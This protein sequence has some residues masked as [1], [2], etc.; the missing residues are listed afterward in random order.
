[1]P[2]PYF[3]SRPAGL[4]VRFRVPED[5]RLRI[6]L[7]FVVRSMHGLRGDAARL[8]A[9]R[10]AVALSAVFHRLR[11]GDDVTGFDPKKLID[12]AQRAAADGTLREWTATGVRIGAVDFGAVTTQGPQDTLDFIEAMKAAAAIAP[13]MPMPVSAPVA[14]VPEPIAP[15][16]PLLSEAIA[17]YLKDLESAKRDPKT[18]LESRH[19]LRILLGVVG[20]VAVGTLSQ[21][22]VRAFFDA[23]RHWPSN[24]TKRPEY[25][26]LSVPEVLVLSKA[27]K[28]P[29]P[30][31][32][33]L[34]K[35]RQRLSA[36]VQPLLAA[37]VISH[38][39]M[40]G[41]VRMSA[42][43]ASAEVET[44]R[45]FTTAELQAVFAPLAYLPWAKKYPHRYWA[46]ILG[47]YSGAR[48][49]EVA[50]L[51]VDDIETV[52]GVPGFHVNRRF[53]GQKIKNAQS[54]RFVP[55]AQPVLDVG[56][57]RFV[58]EA[59]KAGQA[60]LFPDLPNGT[61]LG[62]GRQL[63]RQFSAYIKK[64]GVVEEG[65]GFHAFRH[66]FATLLSEAGVET[67]DIARLTGHLD[68]K[69]QGSVLEKFYIDRKTLPLRVATLARFTPAVGMPT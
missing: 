3:L 5:L 13:S 27:R 64:C 6:G 67:T 41:I 24:A 57:L 35:H 23:V 65:M 21:S 10:Q 14:P 58:E 20:D 37:R 53:P 9:A 52:E 1:M 60:R 12:S 15:T 42:H 43:A 48:V 45:P 62:F 49:T 19:S 55:L 28:E 22:H 31:A 2:K 16:G 51:Y 46:P 25:R 18:V 40:A 59:R 8:S 50:Q 36:F 66:T 32:H 54:R 30:A 47:L 39:P 56:F 44:G 38:N 17:D 29:E 26:S 61:G 11:K 34:N 69:A 68:G 7:R 4:Y 63:S 33:T